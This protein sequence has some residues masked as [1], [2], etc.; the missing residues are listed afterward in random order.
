[1]SQFTGEEYYTH[2]TQDEDHEIRNAGPGIGAVGKNYTRREKGTMKMSCQEKN[3]VSTNLGLMRVEGEYN[4]YSMNVYGMS[5]S[6]NSWI[7]SQ[8]QPSRDS[9]YE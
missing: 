5:S 6:S 1:M 7:H 4:P 9:S 8:A 3:F 2:A